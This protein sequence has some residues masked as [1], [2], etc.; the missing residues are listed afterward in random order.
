MILSIN[1]P[2]QNYRD[3]YCSC[4]YYECFFINYVTYQ[5]YTYIYILIYLW[6]YALGFY[7]NGETFSKLFFVVVDVLFYYKNYYFVL[8]TLLYIIRLEIYIK[9]SYFIIIR[10]GMIY[11]SQDVIP[12]FIVFHMHIFGHKMQQKNGLLLLLYDVFG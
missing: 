5:L 1:T 10:I 12:H 8:C 11:T 4:V 3:R 7:R 2:S 9:Y 6:L